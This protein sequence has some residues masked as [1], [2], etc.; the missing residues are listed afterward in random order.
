MPYVEVT[1]DAIGQSADVD[2]GV[3]SMYFGSKEELF[4]LLL[5]KQLGEWYE[6]LEERFEDVS[7]SLAADELAEVLASSLVER[8]IMVRYLSLL[9]VV[10]EQNMEVMEVFSFQ[11]WRLERMNRVARS[12]EKVS[13]SLGDGA[14]FRLLHLLQLVAAGLEPAANP[15]GSAAFDRGNPDF[16]AHFINLEDELKRFA[17]NHLSS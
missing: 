16:D 4:L 13:Q 6:S 11:R 1:L 3:A 17:I 12:L 9:P 2:R 8:S 5:K 15:K 14:G 7:G 10:L